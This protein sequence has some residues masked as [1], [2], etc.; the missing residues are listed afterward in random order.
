M[1]KVPNPKVFS[2]LRPISILPAIS[3]I[4]ERAVHLQMT[5]FL[6][7]YKIL[8]DFQAGFRAGHSTTTALVHVTDDIARGIDKKEVTALVALDF[9]KAFDTINHSLLYAKLKYYGFSNSAARFI[10]SYLTD[11]KQKVH[12]DD[13]VSSTQDVTSGVPQGSILGPLLFIVYTNELFNSVK[14]CQI[15]AYADDTQVYLSFRLDQVQDAE[16]NINFDLDNISKLAALHNLKLNPNKSYLMV[17]GNNNLRKYLLE[18][19]NIKIDNKKL[20]IVNTIKNLRVHFDPNSKF[21]LHVNHLVQR[22]FSVLKTL[23]SHRHVLCNPLKKLLTDSLVLSHFNYCDS[24]YGPF[25]DKFQQNRIQ[26][27]QNYCARFI[28][29]LRKYDHISAKIL[30]L[31]WLTMEQRRQVH[32]CCFVHKIIKTKY[33]ANLYNRLIH[34]SSFH[35]AQIRSRHYMHIPRHS[36]AFFQK[37]FSYRAPKYFNKVIVKF[38]DLSQASFKHKIKYYV[39]NEANF[40]VC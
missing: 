26:K 4:L 11:R 39:R 2:D 33:P 16:D 24:V 36:S 32:F 25:L 37:S 19:F 34:R 31:N 38:A 28:F 21:N 7:E 18:N 8:S 17:F 20:E 9:S 15:Q 6:A 5:S 35:N 13:L 14:N 29:G 3:K 30:E 12:I 22:S 23:Y 10:I 27:I 40:S 1:P